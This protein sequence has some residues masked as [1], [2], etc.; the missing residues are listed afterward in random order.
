MKMTELRSNYE[1]A[2][3]KGK[4]KTIYRP[5][6]IVRY[7]TDIRMHVFYN[8][9][10]NLPSNSIALDFG[11][12]IGGWTA[13]LQK[14]FGFKVVGIDISKE[15]IKRAKK[16]YYDEKIHFL[17][18][19]CQHLPFKKE[20]FDIVFSSD[21]LG[22]IPDVPRALKEIFKVLKKRGA[23][24]IYSEASFDSDF[25]SQNLIKKI[26]FDPWAHS[27]TFRHV[28]LYP[29]HKLLDIIKDVGFK[30]ISYSS[31]FI[32]S[33]F[34]T[35][36]QAF[37]VGLK[38]LRRKGIIGKLNKLALIINNFL[39]GRCLLFLLVYTEMKIFGKKF[40]GRGVFLKMTKE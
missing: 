31:A 35:D 30:V 18:A 32:F 28:S 2:F 1:K 7:L 8:N 16:T 14:T 15:A 4:W 26:G 36:P 24:S 38:M 6:S 20:A 11:C 37:S 12:G 33:Y 3:R 5:Y 22:H 23:V 21:V 27:I 10:R 34:T 13:F 17:V 9:L 25:F 29:L 39:L 19:D 40:T